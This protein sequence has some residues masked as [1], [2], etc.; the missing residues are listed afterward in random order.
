VAALLEGSDASLVARIGHVAVLYRRSR[1]K[2][3]VILP[4]A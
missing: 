4:R 1:D 3:L 2:P